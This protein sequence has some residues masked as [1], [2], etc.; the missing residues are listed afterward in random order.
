M[1]AIFAHLK[2][3]I[4]RTPLISPYPLGLAPLYFSRNLVFHR[5]WLNSLNSIHTITLFRQHFWYTY[6]SEVV[7]YRFFIAIDT[8]PFIFA[9][10]LSRKHFAP[11]SFFTVQ[12]CFLW[13]LGVQKL[14]TLV[15]ISFEEYDRIGNNPVSHTF[16][17]VC[18]WFESGVP[19]MK[20]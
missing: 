9:Y 18:R 3:P 2:N 20:S 10:P 19:E 16:F 5:N 13:F 7:K 12:P 17:Q 1:P 8:L 15:D 14:P 6:C 11:L 4:I